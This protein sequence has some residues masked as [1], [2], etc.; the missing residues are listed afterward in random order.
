MN[1]SNEVQTNEILKEK[2]LTRL[3][4]EIDSQLNN[5]VKYGNLI[6]EYNDRIE[7]L[8]NQIDRYSDEFDYDNDPEGYEF[9]YRLI[10]DFHNEKETYEK[11]VMEWES[12]LEETKKQI[13]DLKLD[14]IIAEYAIHN[15]KE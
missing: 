3:K 5:L 15:F 13:S 7:D 14:I 11:Y 10:S 4:N 1:N 6:E 12:D 8:Q 2:V 9:D